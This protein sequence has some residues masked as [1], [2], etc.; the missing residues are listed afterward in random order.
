MSTGKA[1]AEKTT[2]TRPADLRAQV[3]KLWDKGEL[4]AQMIDRE[5]RFPRRLILKGPT[6]A[7]IAE[8]FESVRSWA[9]E[10][11][12][13]PYCRIELKTFSHRI[14]GTNALPGEVWI[15]SPDDA[16]AMLGKRTEAGRFERMAEETRRRQPLLLNWLAKRPLKA[17]DLAGQWSLLM[18]VVAWLQA[19]PRPGIYLRQVDIPGVHS[20]FIET[21]RA[22]LSELLDLCLPQE[23]VNPDANGISGFTAR[24]GFRDKPVRIRFRVLDPSTSPLPGLGLPDVA[25]DSRSFAEWPISVGRVF[26]TENETNFLAFPEVANSLLIFGSGYGWDSVSGIPWLADCRI[27]YW[28]DID[29]HGFAILNQ[30]RNK[31]GHVESF[32]MDRET[33]MMH[34]SVWGN[35]K[36]QARQDLPLLTP[37]EK[38]LFDDLRDNRIRKNLRLEQE[39]IGFGWLQNA[40]LKLPG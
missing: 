1:V 33:L 34:R 29:T 20:K 40:I 9:K 37:E 12:A 2:W 16:L 4:L 35:E 11:M 7:E 18:D 32:L 23:A 28:G 24:Y 19:H 22:V 5:N 13:A 21:H 27:Y 15:D 26:I 25:L 10:L 39:F 14:F 36:D 8:R 3:Q 17:L 30:L 31:F 38:A 6:S